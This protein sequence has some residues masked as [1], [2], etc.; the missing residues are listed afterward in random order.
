M[1]KCIK[2]VNILYK[3]I[4]WFKGRIIGKGGVIMLAFQKKMCYNRGEKRKKGRY[5]P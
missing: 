4:K 5:V 1:H 2:F 3:D